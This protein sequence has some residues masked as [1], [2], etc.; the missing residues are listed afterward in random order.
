MSIAT[1]AKNGIRLTLANDN[2]GWVLRPAVEEVLQ[3]L[4]RSL[5]IALLSVERGTRVVRYHAVTT[6]KGVLHGAPWV[7]FRCGL[8]V[9]DVTS[10]TVDLARLHSRG[11]GILVGD[12]AT[13]GVDDPCTLFEVLEQVGVD[14][15]A[16]TLMQR[17]V[18]GDDITL[19]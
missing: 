5:G 13:G 15:A 10:V 18:D 6:T 19:N 4:L 14:E 1:C 17:A 9:P 16:C 3:D 11:N 7:V 12:G 8:H 2:V